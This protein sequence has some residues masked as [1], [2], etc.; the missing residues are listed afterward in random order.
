MKK[1]WLV[2]VATLMMALP[3]VAQQKTLTPEEKAQRQA[4][5]LENRCL[6]L[7]SALALDDATTIKFV[8][9]YKRYN[10]DMRAVR[11][12]FKMHKP[13]KADM[14]AGEPREELTDAQVEENILARFAMSRAIL[15][16]REAYYK[17]FRTFMN[18][19]QVQKLYQLEKQ[20]G[21]KMQQHK[22]HSP[23]KPMGPRPQGKPMPRN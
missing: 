22:Q 23:K 11:R 6:Q 20:Q 4:V 10:N 9:A 18:P 1:M 17:E 7:A 5:K 16:V 19:K 15:D 14:K 12:Q 8:D 3:V 21:S 13:K 2:A